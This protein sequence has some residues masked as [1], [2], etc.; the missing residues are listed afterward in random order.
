[1]T[2]QANP[3]R[4]GIKRPVQVWYLDSAN[5]AT[6]LEWMES[7]GYPHAEQM[8]ALR[9]P[10]KFQPEYMQACLVAGVSE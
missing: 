6:L 10:Q 8:Y 9:N 2:E 5:L 1:M 4:P 7:Q 3:S